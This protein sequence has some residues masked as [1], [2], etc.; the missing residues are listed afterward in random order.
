M[1]PT[2]APP[3]RRLRLLRPSPLVAAL[4]ALDGLML[5]LAV[6]GFVVSAAA[7]EPRWGLVRLGDESNLPTWFSS[8]QLLLV[9]LG[10]GLL[11]ARDVRRPLLRTAPLL[12]GPAFFLLLSL[13]EVAMLHERL[14]D[15]VKAET[16]AGD[17]LRTG[18]WMFVYAPLALLMLGA[19]L[20]AYRPYWRGRRGVIILALAGVA[21]YGAAAVGL[22]FAANFVVEGSLAQK[23]LGFAEEIGEMV[24]ATTLLWA[25]AVLL[26]WEGVR[27]EPGI[28][29]APD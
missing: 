17:G 21:L 9:A 7:G 26:R 22:E 6:A 16:G 24:G 29:R 20:R 3:R 4:Y 5:A 10:L 8:A 11:A 12:L 28:R 1:L 27:I 23:G 25:V 14:G 2:L 13:D 18:P 15:W 19:A